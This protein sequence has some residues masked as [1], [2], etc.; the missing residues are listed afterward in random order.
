[1][2]SN[3][4]GYDRVY[5]Y[6]DSNVLKNKFGITDMDEL[7]EKETSF[8]AVRTA[9]LRNS[10]I[11]GNFDFKH[12]LKIHGYMFQDVYE[13][14]GRT[15]SVDIGKGNMFCRPMFIASMAADIFTKLK[16][17]NYLVGLSEEEMPKKLAYYLGEI[18]ALHPFREGNGRT[19][20]EFIK[21][22]ASAAGFDLSYIHISKE[23]MIEASIETFDLK[24]EKME[25]LLSHGLLT[26]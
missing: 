3:Q 12:L 13:W 1:M 7:H 4:I 9:G 6:P 22:L 5:C 15:R 26:C 24:Y 18:N 25:Q 16:N 21:Q 19:Q 17:D 14:A 20:R 10:P 8:T 11:R 2:K 23:Q